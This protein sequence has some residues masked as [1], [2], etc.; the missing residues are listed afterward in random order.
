MNEIQENFFEQ[1]GDQQMVAPR[2]AQMRATAKRREKAPPALSAQEKKLRD[3]AKQARRYRAGRRRQ[4]KE[5]YN[6]KHKQGWHDLRKALRQ[7]SIDTPE[8][9]IDHVAKARWIHGADLDTR[10]LALSI[11]GSKI[12]RLRECNG[13]EPFDDALPGEPDTVFQIVRSMIMKRPAPGA[14]SNP[15]LQT[16]E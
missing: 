16:R 3:Q 9:L 14:D 13:L 8:N 6:G 10:Y 7:M 5:H 1:L 15:T 11:I 4:L 2:K 12:V